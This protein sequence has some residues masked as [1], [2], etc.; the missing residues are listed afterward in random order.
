V[1]I[2]PCEAAVNEPLIYQSWGKNITYIMAYDFDTANVTDITS[3][4]ISDQQLYRSRRMADFMNESFIE[5]TLQEATF[6]LTEFRQHLISKHK[7]T[8]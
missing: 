7:N 2:D 4:Y 1:H 8:F 3:S 5:S 6:N